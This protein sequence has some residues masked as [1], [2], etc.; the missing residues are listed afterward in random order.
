VSLVSPGPVD[1]PLWDPIDPDSRPG[2]TPRAQMLGADAV[3]DAV[4]W[5]ATRPSPVNIDELRLSHA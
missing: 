3:A 5:V 2:F 4:H 1:T